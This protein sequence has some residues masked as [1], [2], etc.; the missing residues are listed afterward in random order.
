MY[1]YFLLTAA[2]NNTWKLCK[3]PVK[4]FTAN[5]LMLFDN[6]STVT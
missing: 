3:M 4:F 6:Q 5:M 2:I 1:G